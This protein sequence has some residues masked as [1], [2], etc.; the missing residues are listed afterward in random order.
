MIVWSDMCYI[1]IPF[2]NVGNDAFVLFEVKAK[3]SNQTVCW[4]HFQLNKSTL[5]SK[6]ITLPQY[7]TPVIV[8]AMPPATSSGR[9]TEVEMM[10]TRRTGMESSINMM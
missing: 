5:D 6:T 3:G 4:M 10:V 9:V 8:S 1:Q 7:T 2:E